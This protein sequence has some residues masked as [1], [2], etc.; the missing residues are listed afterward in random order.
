MTHVEQNSALGREARLP[1]ATAFVT[2][3]ALSAVAWAIVVLAVI[4]CWA[5]LS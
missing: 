3:G 4:G 5:A 1:P 2:I